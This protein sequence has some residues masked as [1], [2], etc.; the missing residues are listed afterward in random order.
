MCEIV[1]ILFFNYQFRWCLLYQLFVSLIGC[2]SSNK[3]KKNDLTLIVSTAVASV[4]VVA[5][6]I[7]LVRVH[8]A[9]KRG[10]IKIQQG[11]QDKM[12]KASFENQAYACQ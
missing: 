10:K 12:T 3:A 6:I 1:Y 5:L 8:A 9:R 2:K 4:V 7:V 11:K